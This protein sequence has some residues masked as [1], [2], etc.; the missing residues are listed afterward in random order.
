[1]H[2]LLITPN[3]ASLKKNK[4]TYFNHQWYSKMFDY[5]LHIQVVRNLRDEIFIH[6]Y[7]SQSV[8]ERRIG[9]DILLLSISRQGWQG[10]VLAR[11]HTSRHSWEVPL[12]TASD[13]VEKTSPPILRKRMIRDT[14]DTLHN[15]L[16]QGIQTLKYISCQLT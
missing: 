6:Y 1:M 9:R 13:M 16:D 7:I 4:K 3:K 2:Y 8:H 12:V 5:S 15:E 11:S 14:S 10:S